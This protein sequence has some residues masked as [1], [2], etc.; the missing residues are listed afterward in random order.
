[1]KKIRHY[2]VASIAI[3]TLLSCNNTRKA[4]NQTKSAYE[5]RC[6]GITSLSWQ[7]QIQGADAETTAKIITELTAAAQADAKKSADL[8]AS[9]QV[10]FSLKSDIAKVINQNVTQTSQVSD[11]FWEQ[12][13]RFGESMCLFLN[14][15]DRGDISKDT[16]K[17]I[18]DDI[19]KL[20]TSHNDYVL[21][22][23]KRH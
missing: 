7:K 20:V 1:M 5:N 10:D 19:R 9:G 15:L 11:E 22:K 12:E 8:Q 21:N 3:I 2:F 16:K 4:I 17:E 23:K 14:L 6:E 13:N 18:I